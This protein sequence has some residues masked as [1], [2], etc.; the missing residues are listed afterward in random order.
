MTTRLMNCCRR[1]Y[2]GLPTTA[3]PVDDPRR[4]IFREVV[5]ESIRKT[6]GQMFMPLFLVKAAV[7]WWKRLAIFAYLTQLTADFPAARREF[8]WLILPFALGQLLEFAFNR[9]SSR[10]FRR[11]KGVSASIVLR[12]Q[13][14]VS[15]PTMPDGETYQARLSRGLRQIEQ[16]WNQAIWRVNSLIGVVSSWSVIVGASWEVGIA[17]LL[18]NLVTSHSVVSRLEQ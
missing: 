8:G 5:T 14:R 1:Q 9:E 6:P 11:F 17:L 2:A 16:L 13:I 18:I 10:Y 12:R 4:R 15:I 3:P 7:T